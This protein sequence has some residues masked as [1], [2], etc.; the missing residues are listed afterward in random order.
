MHESMLAQFF[1][2]IRNCIPAGVDENH[3]HVDGDEVK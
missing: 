2:F 3:S 1:Q